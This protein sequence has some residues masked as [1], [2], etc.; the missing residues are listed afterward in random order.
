MAHAGTHDAPLATDWQLPVALWANV[1]VHGPVV[2]VGCVPKLPSVHVRAVALLM[3][4]PEMQ[5][6][7]HWLP[8]ATSSH[9]P[10]RRLA[11]EAEH[12]AALHEGCD[13]VNSPRLLHMST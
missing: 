7:E 1:A 5:A 13:V 8:L 4:K 9:V 12:V 2:H 6:G 10:S 3:E 11:N